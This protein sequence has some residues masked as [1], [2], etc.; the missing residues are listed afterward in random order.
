MQRL[1]RMANKEFPEARRVFEANP[2]APLIRR[3][4][5]LSANRDHDGFIKLCALQLW[6]N[7]LALEGLLVEPEE[8][9]TRVQSFMEEAAEKRSPILL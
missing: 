5:S 1:L 8:T 9:V 6:S 3:L 4:G 2:E 7:A